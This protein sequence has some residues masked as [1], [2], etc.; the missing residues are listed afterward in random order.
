[1]K[2]IFAL[3]ALVLVASLSFA[4][5]TPLGRR[6][7][8]CPIY[9]S[10]RKGLLRLPDGE[11]RLSLQWEVRAPGPVSTRQNW[12]YLRIAG[13]TI[14]LPPNQWEIA[15]SQDADHPALTLYSKDKQNRAVFML[16]IN[17]ESAFPSVYKFFLN[18]PSDAYE[19]VHTLNN[20]DFSLPCD[21]HHSARS[22]VR[23][24]VLMIVKSNTI[25]PGKVLHLYSDPG[26][27]CLVT[28]MK[29]VGAHQ[30]WGLSAYFPA[31]G[32]RFH[33]TYVVQ[34]ETDATALVNQL[35]LTNRNAVAVSSLP[36]GLKLLPEKLRMLGWQE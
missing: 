21:P 8:L 33:A 18:I 26:S 3:S 12:L 15:K 11:R 17:E 27:G 10:T 35:T 13:A 14:P 22:L 19:F 32:R 20:R 29:S 1:M 28:V 16:S 4:L 6:L 30:D 2:R 23:D 34:K 24:Y 36:A 5:L 7:T 25:P 9:E 31:V